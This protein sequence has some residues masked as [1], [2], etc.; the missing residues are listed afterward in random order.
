MKI[1]VIA[2]HPDDEVLGCGGT[3]K[4]YSRQGHDVHVCYV[5]KGYEPDWT[6][7]YLKNKAAEVA[8]V[9]RILAIKKYYWLDFPTVKLDTTPQ[10]ELNDCLA[11]I[12]R[13]IKPDVIYTPGQ[14]DL[15][16]DHRIIFAATLVAARPLPGSSIKEVLSYEVP[17]E[18][19]WGRNLANFVPNYYTELA[20]DDLQTK[21]EAMRAY[22]SEIKNFPHPRSLEVIEALAKL[23]G[24]EIGCAAAEAFMVIR[25]VDYEAN[26]F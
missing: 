18:T 2:P 14:G 6:S 17:S 8:N 15:N 25:K 10:K 5:T 3:I 16:S 21:L 12:M 22:G 19:E 1:L 24:S 4:K 9:Q 13:E 7:E 20:Q 23:R 11:E 26:N